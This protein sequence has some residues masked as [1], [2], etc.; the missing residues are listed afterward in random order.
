MTNTRIF[1][2][3]ALVPGSLNDPLSLFSNPLKKIV[4]KINRETFLIKNKTKIV[5]IES[6]ERRTYVKITFLWLP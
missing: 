6:L 4:S 3:N 1:G 2:R 5:K